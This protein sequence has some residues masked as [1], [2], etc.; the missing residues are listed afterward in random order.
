MPLQEREEPL[1]CLLCF[2]ENDVPVRRRIQRVVAQDKLGQ[3][4]VYTGQDLPLSISL[5]T[6]KAFKGDNILEILENPRRVHPREQLEEPTPLI[7][8]RDVVAMVIGY[9]VFTT[10]TLVAGALRLAM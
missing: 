1:Y 4:R 7:S 9:F 8:G 3:V 2:H 10:A 5:Y 6:G